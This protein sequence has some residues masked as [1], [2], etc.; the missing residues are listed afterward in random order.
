MADG[1]GL[2]QGVE[3]TSEEEIKE[4]LNNLG[5]EY[6]FGCYSEKNPKACQLLG[7]FMESISRETSKAFQVYETNCI[8]NNFGASCN[9]AGH[10][11]IVGHGDVEA[12][13]DLGYKYLVKGCEADFSKS[14]FLAGM[15]HKLKLPQKITT[16][17]NVKTATK[18]FERGCELDHPSS[19][20]FYA[21]NLMQPG[22][23][24]NFQKAAEIF[25]KACNMGAYPACHNLSVM[26]RKGEGVAQD[27]AM[28]DK[29][30]NQAQSIHEQI[31]KEKERVKF[32]EGVET[33]GS[34][35]L[36]H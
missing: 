36:K 28:A 15:F 24:Q 19:C 14:C 27:S 31:I 5:I 4:Y 32:Q 13:P 33:A 23:D 12:D 8:D 3:L 20:Q 6:R 10:Y 7:E 30:M 11:K 17:Q 34:A 1:V 29:F 22:V 9:K 26:Y 2:S 21:N 25:D 35:P 16:E 18:M